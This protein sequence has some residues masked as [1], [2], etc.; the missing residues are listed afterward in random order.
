MEYF[1]L[2]NGE[3]IPAL[4]FGVYEIKQRKTKK[5]VLEA[6]KV[7]YRSIDNAQVYYNEKE[8]GDAIKESEIS[9]DEI[10]LTSKNWVSNAGYDKT[11]KAFNKSLENLQTDY[12]DLFLI[13]EPFGDYYGSYRALQDLQKEG[14]VLSIG[15]SNFN[16]ARLI[17]LV[18]NNDIV[19]QVNQVETTPYFQQHEANEYM[20]ELGVC[21]QAWGPFSEGINNLFKNP[22]LVE[23]AE[24]YSK[25]TPQIILRWLIDRDIPGIC[26][27]VKKK[28]MLEN[29]DIFD[30]ELSNKEIKKIKE[31]DTGKSP[32]M[33]FDDP[34][35][36]KELNEEIV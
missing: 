1:K 21:H 2:N 32:F 36:A 29:I 31:I 18:M 15:V 16:S 23:I 27:S 7:G 28:R 30:F 22:I 8:V 5:A 19:P 12:L 35:T 17:D 34:D 6:L 20:D 3:K 4:S 26:R 25:S 9:R 14:K 33:D 13:H 10:F 11:I 24:K